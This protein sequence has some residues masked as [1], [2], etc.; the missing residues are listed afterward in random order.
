MEDQDNLV[1][2]KKSILAIFPLPLLLSSV[3]FLTIII[4]I[5]IISD[6]F[7][8][9]T[10]VQQTRF[11]FHSFLSLLITSILFR[12]QII[13]IQTDSSSNRENSTILDG[14]EWEFQ[15]LWLI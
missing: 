5:I 10:S 4:I 12:V 13:K 1:K 9:L 14:D 8:I 15:F 6:M 3:P 7:L 2:I 11:N